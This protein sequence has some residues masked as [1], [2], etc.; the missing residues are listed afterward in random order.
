MNDPCAHAYEIARQIALHDF[1]GLPD[2]V[3]LDPDVR[4]PYLQLAVKVLDLTGSPM[5]MGRDHIGMM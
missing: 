3:E 1:P 2:I 5:L 4:D